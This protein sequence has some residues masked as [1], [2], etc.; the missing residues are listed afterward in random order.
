[1]R[2]KA[3]KALAMVLLLVAVM[4]TLTACGGVPNGKYV[5][6][7]PALQAISSTSQAIIIKGSNFTLDMGLAGATTVKYEYDKTTG[8]IT[9]DGGLSGLTLCEYKDG[10]IW[11]AGSEFKKQ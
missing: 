1:M 10:S 9:L 3:V 4:G 6:T 11:F 7:D 2:T 5:P 8:A